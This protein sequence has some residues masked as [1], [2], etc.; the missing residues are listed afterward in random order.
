[1]AMWTYSLHIH[2]ERVCSTRVAQLIRRVAGI[3][4]LN[5]KPL[6]S[7]PHLLA[8]R[9][10]KTQFAQ[11][12]PPSIQVM[13]V[14]Q[15]CLSPHWSQRKLSSKWRVWGR[16]RSTGCAAL[17]KILAVT[18]RRQTGQQ[19]LTPISCFTEKEYHCRCP[20][21]PPSRLALVHRLSELAR[22]AL[23]YQQRL[24]VAR[25]ESREGGEAL[26]DLCDFGAE[27]PSLRCRIQNGFLRATGSRGCIELQR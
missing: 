8:N 5:V 26:N 3:I 18:G 14:E 15:N 17:Q 4:W 23:H 2:L 27:L 19:D 24:C 7:H 20:S 6:H 21:S 11:T 9:W 1:M 12:I 13:R 16:R 25:R 22:G 10:T